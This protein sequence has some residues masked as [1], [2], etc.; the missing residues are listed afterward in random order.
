MVC[1][2]ILN[3]GSIPTR[4]TRN[5]RLNRFRITFPFGHGCAILYK[6]PAD[7]DDSLSVPR[8]Y[9]CASQIFIR[10]ENI[11]L[12]AFTVYCSSMLRIIR[13]CR[14]WVSGNKSIKSRLELEGIQLKE[15]K[16]Y[17]K[18]DRTMCTTW[19][20]WRTWTTEPERCKRLDFCK[21]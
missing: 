21:L 1:A 8:I 4:S 14:S 5:T 11:G 3:A 19:C 2:V 17:R 16:V 6:V 18:L 20:T 12:P 9:T 7:L 15:P 10:T 13:N